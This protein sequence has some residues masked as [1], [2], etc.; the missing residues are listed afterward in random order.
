MV[1][2]C[3]GLGIILHLAWV[4]CLFFIMDEQSVPVHSVPVSDTV[5]L[6][7]PVPE[8]TA[9]ATMVQPT[10]TL[11]QEHDSDCPQR[12]QCIVKR[13]QK[14]A[15]AQ[16]TPSLE[17]SASPPS[18]DAFQQAVDTFISGTDS[19]SFQLPGP[20]GPLLPPSPSYD[21]DFEWIASV[22]RIDEPASSGDTSGADSWHLLSGTSVTSPTVADAV[23]EWELSPLRTGRLLFDTSPAGALPIAASFTQ[24]AQVD[25][26]HP[27]Q[28][29][30]TIPDAPSIS[31][32]PLARPATLRV[33]TS[34]AKSLHSH[35]VRTSQHARLRPVVHLKASVGNPVAC[36]KPRP[37]PSARGAYASYPSLTTSW[38]KQ[39][40]G[41][42][43]KSSPHV[44]APV[45][46]DTSFPLPSAARLLGAATGSQKRSVSF[47]PETSSGSSNK[48]IKHSD[49]HSQ[50]WTRALHLWCELC[51]LTSAC[52]RLLQDILHSDNRHAL[53]EQLL[54]RVSD[55]TALR[56]IAVLWQLFTTVK[57]LEL[58]I[59]SL[60][61]VQLVDAIHTLQRSRSHHASLHSL[62]VL[63]A[64]RWF[65]ST[66]QPDGFPSLYQGLFHSKAWQSSSMR[67]E[68]IPLPLAFVL[69]LETELVFE[70]LSRPEAVFAGSVLLCIWCSLRFSDA[71]HVRLEQFFIG[72]DSIRSISYRTKSRKFM[73]F[74]CIFGGLY[75]LPS[76]HSWLFHWLSAMEHALELNSSSAAAP[77]YIFFGFDGASVRPL[78]YAEAL[79]R[80]RRMLD[81]WG[82]ITSLQTLQYTLHSMKVT[83]LA[84]FRP[85]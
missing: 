52:S 20:E 75:R 1:F 2:I 34:R 33:E 42:T 12:A 21:A 6:P 41:A 36:P 71:Q 19:A 15:S 29:S 18:V 84:F 67:K 73:P 30:P 61:Q 78:S 7:L 48:V 44:K 5:H 56:Y 66:V 10:C 63:K 70:R 82:G 72:F 32:K 68:A 8:T 17:Q 76:N 35:P 9:I 25:S 53:L 54:R 31:G 60:S 14:R 58:E 65:A 77:D 43:S 49:V 85:A 11:V 69:W 81:M 24:E 40:E 28:L 57:D 39:A 46:M 51:E 26:M 4:A 47:I 74:G 83:L 55:N 3:G 27:S 80:L 50:H 13:F 23:P 62:N 38:G 22:D 59:S 64:I 45:G 16:P 37:L 79:V